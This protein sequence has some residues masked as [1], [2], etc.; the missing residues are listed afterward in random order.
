MEE[1]AKVESKANIVGSALLKKNARVG[2]DSTLRGD[3][4][5]GPWSNFVRE[6]EAIGEIT[7][8]GYGAFARRVTFQEKNHNTSWAG[9]QMRFYDNVVGESLPHVTNGP[10]RV[11]NDVWIG[12]D[13]TILSGVKIGHGAIIGARSVVTK[14]VSPYEVVAGVPATHRK[15]RFDEQTREQLLDLAWWEWSDEKIANNK[16]FFTTDLTPV[17][18]ITSLVR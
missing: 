2:P 5:V 12:A 8:G 3:V 9:T 4:T 16:E 7:I 10:I 15:W 18:D 17:E 1:G 14:D 13:V 6:I 11:G